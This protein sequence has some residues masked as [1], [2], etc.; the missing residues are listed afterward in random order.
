M[1]SRQ[2]FRQW[3][4]V[5]SCIGTFTSACRGAACECCLSPTCCSRVQQF[6]LCDSLECVAPDGHHIAILN[7]TSDRHTCRWH[8]QALFLLN[9]ETWLFCAEGYISEKGRIIFGHGVPGREDAITRVTE[10]ECWM[11]CEEASQ[12]KS[13]VYMHSSKRCW[14]KTTSIHIEKSKNWIRT[15]SPDEPTGALQPSGLV[16]QSMYTP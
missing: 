5:N 14:L 7:S 4:A 10:A 2:A 12:C 3:H 16:Q 6:R 1:L 11:E 15:L 8:C 13:A 9:H